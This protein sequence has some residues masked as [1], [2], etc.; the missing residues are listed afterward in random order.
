MFGVEFK[1]AEHGI[2]ATECLELRS[3]VQRTGIFVAEDL[4]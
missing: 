1:G 2:F 4:K 3:K